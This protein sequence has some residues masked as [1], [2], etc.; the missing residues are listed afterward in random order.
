MTLTTVPS[1][2]WRVNVDGR[3]NRS[4]TSV[5]TSRREARSYRST[6][7]NQGFTDK[8]M[9]TVRYDV[10]GPVAVTA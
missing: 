9:H 2:I 6:L 8:Q 4:L 10:S 3:A 5:F 1:F 7:R